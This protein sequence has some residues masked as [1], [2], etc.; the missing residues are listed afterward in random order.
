MAFVVDPVD[1]SHGDQSWLLT[2]SALVQ[3]MT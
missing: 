1:L 3:L 2:S